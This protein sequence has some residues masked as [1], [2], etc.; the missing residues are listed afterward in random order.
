MTAQRNPEPTDN[1]ELMPFQLPQ[2]PYMSADLVLPG[3]LDKYLE[4]DNL[5]VPT[6][7]SVSFTPNSSSS[8]S[9]KV[10][11]TSYTSGYY[12]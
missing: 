11:A 3:V 10:Y 8:F 4:D 1:E 9:L 6:S 5:W 2:V 12:S 7:D